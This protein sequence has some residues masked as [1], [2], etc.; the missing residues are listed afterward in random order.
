M[1]MQRSLLALALAVGLAAPALA[2][3]EHGRSRRSRNGRSAGPFGK[4]DRAP[5]AARL[6]GLSRGLPGL[7]RPVAAVVPQS[8]RAGRPGLHD[9]AG[10]GDRR[11]IQGQGRPERRRARCS[12]GR[13]GRPTVSRRRSR[14]TRPRAR[15]MAARLPPDLSV[16]AKARTYERG[17]PWFLLD[18]FT[19][20]QEQGPDYIAAL[21]TGLRG[22]RRRASSCRRRRTTTSISRAMPS[23]CR[24]R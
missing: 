9:G 8:R 4:Y 20:Y 14:T 5:V 10:R 16:I 22:C 21:L 23:A 18:I 1:T 3:D 19:Q 6:Q 11:R 15:P 2:A 12:S 17:F 7:S 13:R 24:R